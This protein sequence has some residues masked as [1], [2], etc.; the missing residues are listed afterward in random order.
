MAMNNRSKLWLLSF[1]GLIVLLLSMGIGSVMI[2]PAETFGLLMNRLFHWQNLPVP[3]ETGQAIL[4]NIRFPRALLAFICGGGLAVS[5]TLMQS[6]L[7]NPLASSYTL[8]VSSGA[9]L[10]ASVVII[11]GISFL[12]YFTLPFFGLLAGLATVFLALGIARKVDSRLNSHSIILTGMAFSLFANAIITILLS[13]R[14]EEMQRL[15]YWQ[16]GSFAGL[17]GQPLLIIGGMVLAGGFLAQAFSRQMD[18]LTLGDE[19]AQSVGVEARK[20]KWFFLVIATTLTGSIVA[21]VGI[22]GFVD[23]F[24]P[25]IARKLFGA[26]HRW[27]LPGAAILGG[28]FMVLCD[29]LA[30]T[31]LSPLELPVGAIT[32]ALGAPFFIYLYFSPRR[33]KG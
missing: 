5:G 11:T 4:W 1:L 10:G 9:A 17:G 21:F 23:L 19:Q 3:D 33:Q 12:G 22:I 30:R 26:N 24:T 8:G 7:G 18:I 27:V 29:L 14:R 25:H 6:V 20:M 32:A 28:T 2:P 16:M 31:L 13:L 15:I